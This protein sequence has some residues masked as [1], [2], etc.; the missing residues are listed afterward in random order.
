MPRVH[1]RDRVSNSTNHKQR[2]EAV[3]NRKNTEEERRLK[4]LGEKNVTEEELYDM[5]YR[6]RDLF[7]K[8]EEEQGDFVEQKEPTI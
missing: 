4:W 7:W 2:L 5:G 6:R 1:E 3:K 8:K